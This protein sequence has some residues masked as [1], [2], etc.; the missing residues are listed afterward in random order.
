M[1]GESSTSGVLVTNSTTVKA[2]ALGYCELTVL[3]VGGGGDS[4]YSSSGYGGGGSGYIEW[5]TM[6]LTGPADR[7]LQITVG[8]NR[9]KT[10]VTYSNN[11]LVEA[12]PGY[13]RKYGNGAGGFSGGSSFRSGSC[14]TPGQG[15]SNGQ[16]GADCGDYGGG[17]GSGV[18]VGSIPIRD[19][20]LCRLNKVT[21]NRT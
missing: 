9:Q 11:I 16:D 15:G 14:E 7:D 6:N 21:T 20:M 18:D 4:E 19:F 3:A 17:K 8:G 2:L 5:T 10:S 13:N 1:D 12:Q